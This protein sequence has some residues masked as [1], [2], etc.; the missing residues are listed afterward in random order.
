MG[1]L[2]DCTGHLPVKLALVLGSSVLGT[3]LSP[4]CFPSLTA[5]VVAIFAVPSAWPSEERC[6]QS[7]APTPS[8]F[9]SAPQVS[10]A[11]PAPPAATD[12]L[13][14]MGPHFVGEVE[15]P[16]LPAPR[17]VGKNHYFTKRI[18]LTPLDLL[19]LSFMP[20]L[21]RV[22]RGKIWLTY[23]PAHHWR[24]MLTMVWMPQN[25]LFKDEAMVMKV[26]SFY[27]WTYLVP[28]PRQEGNQD[29]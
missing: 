26:A 18:A 1:T 13:R 7:E 9:P 29:R 23:L 28:G 2:C 14:E 12:V 19:S 11:H 24:K 4:G 8:R 25:W 3:P 17:P 15:F 10:A 6:P 20:D 22:R 27:F 16:E 21:Y 5:G